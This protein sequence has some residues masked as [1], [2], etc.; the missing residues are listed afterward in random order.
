M[1]GPLDA[2]VPGLPG[3]LDLEPELRVREFHDEIATPP[4]RFGVGLLPLNCQPTSGEAIPKEPR[5]ERFLGELLPRGLQGR[6]GELSFD[7]KQPALN[8][9]D[10]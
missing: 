7:I 10:E 8:A 4:L 1:D 6:V 9:I 2:F 3:E 5:K